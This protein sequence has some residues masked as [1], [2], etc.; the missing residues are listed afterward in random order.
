VYDGI[1][2]Q[3][4]PDSPG[5]RPVPRCAP[6]CQPL[7]KGQDLIVACHVEPADILGLQG[8]YGRNP[9]GGRG[10]GRWCQ[11]LGKNIG[12]IEQFAKQCGRETG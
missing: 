7:G 9:A 1:P 11:A 12:R 2:L 4:G 10:V 6:A 8:G 3:Q 5:Y